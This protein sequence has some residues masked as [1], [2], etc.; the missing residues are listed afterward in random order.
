LADDFTLS[1][2]CGM[3]Y[4]SPRGIDAY[5]DDPEE[6]LPMAAPRNVVSRY[7]AIAAAMALLGAYR[8]RTVTKR[9]ESVEI[10]ILD[11]LIPMLRRELSMFALDN[12]IH[13]RSHRSW[14]LA[15][16]GI[17]PNKDGYVFLQVVEDDHW[18][19]LVDWMGSPE[20][21]LDPNLADRKYRYEHRREIDA[22]MAEWLSTV[23]KSDFHI[24]AQSRGLP[25]A[26]V[27]DPAEV[28]ESPQSA[29]RSFDIADGDSLGGLP[30]PYIV[31]KEE[32]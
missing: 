11:T 26:P 20:W 32:R 12:E 21:A 19:Q 24:E 27:N 5:G 31:T 22:N 13:S 9:G 30:L 18:H 2:E 4:L 1:A 8:L 7:A 15:P 17:K 6:V 14:Q 3:S 10:A 16:Y 23:S 29:Y 25:F 28:L